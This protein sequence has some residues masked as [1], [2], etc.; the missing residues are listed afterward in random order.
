MNSM[1]LRMAA[2][3]LLTVCGFCLGDARRQK[4]TARRRTLEAVTELLTRLRQEIAYRRT[5]LG[6][7]YHTLATEYDSS[8]PLG[9]TFRL[10]NC[11]Q[12]MVPPESLK[13]EEAACF[14]ACFADL[15]H[16]DA[17]VALKRYV[18]SDMKRKKSEMQ[19]VFSAVWKKCPAQLHAS[20]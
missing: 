8:N 2:A 16:A 18:H 15:G 6:Q 14:T 10:G 19:R 13:T 1:A 12:Q 20:A 9:N 17:N 7:L 4:L 3:V 5:D 11:F